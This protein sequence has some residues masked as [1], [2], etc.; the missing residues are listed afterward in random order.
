MSSENIDNNIKPIIFPIALDPF[1]IDPSKERFENNKYDATVGCDA[2]TS[3]FCEH[4]LELLFD[5][6]ENMDSSTRSFNQAGIG[7][8]FSEF[9]NTRF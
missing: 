3:S 4:N 8:I 7:N 9:K 2:D 1:V 5:K 6:Q